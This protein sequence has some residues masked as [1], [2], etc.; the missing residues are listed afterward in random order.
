MP[1]K[2]ENIFSRV[3][4][5]LDAFKNPAELTLDGERDVK[6]IIGGVMFFILAALI[7]IVVAYFLKIYL[8]GTD[9]TVSQRRL[10]DSDLNVID[11][12]TLGEL[13][14]GINLVSG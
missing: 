9:F 1:Y 3:I 11:S 6:S 2:K 8:N 5:Y 12:D 10:I 13:K 7:I 14:Q 4:K